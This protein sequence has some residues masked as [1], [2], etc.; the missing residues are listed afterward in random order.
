MF[1]NVGGGGLSA[2]CVVFSNVGGG[3]DV[4][5]IVVKG[6][7]LS[8]LSGF[9]I[10]DYDYKKFD[11]FLNTKRRAI[12]RGEACYKKY[13]DNDNVISYHNMTNE[14]LR[15]IFKAYNVETELRFQRL[16]EASIFDGLA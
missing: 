14:Q 9:D 10:S 8:G 1:D 11:S 13:D 12:L 7:L 16:H 6:T 5:D 4:F 3:A 15:H 2:G